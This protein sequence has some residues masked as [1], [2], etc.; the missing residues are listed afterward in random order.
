[1]Y[2]KVEKILDKKTI[3]NQTKYLI[4]W[5]GFNETTW[6]PAYKIKEDVPDLVKAF[7]TPIKASTTSK[8]LLLSEKPSTIKIPT[9]V[10]ITRTGRTIKIP[11]KLKD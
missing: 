9:P 3:N 4:K 2:Y 10:K 7:E 11:A 6:E 1:M 5:V 8:K